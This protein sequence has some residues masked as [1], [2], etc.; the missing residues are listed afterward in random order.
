MDG[1]GPPRAR[2]IAPSKAKPKPKPETHR[3]Q[4]SEAAKLRGDELN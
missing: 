4:L 1:A 2:P 3:L